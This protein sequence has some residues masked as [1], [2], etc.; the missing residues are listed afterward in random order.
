M[1]H[2]VWIIWKYPEQE[3]RFCISL[4]VQL[5]LD[6]PLM[7]LCCLQL[8]FHYE[9]IIIHSYSLFSLIS[10]WH[11]Q[12]VSALNNKDNRVDAIYTGGFIPQQH[13]C[14]TLSLYSWLGLVTVYFLWVLPS[15]SALC[16]YKASAGALISWENTGATSEQRGTW[17][18]KTLIWIWT[19]NL[20]PHLESFG[21]ISNMSLE[22]YQKAKL[23]LTQKRWYVV[24]TLSV[25]R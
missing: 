24:M 15:C 6:R 22:T 2:L 20:Q 25:A 11:L 1:L 13:A 19:A 23:M 17:M 8:P 10:W 16:S 5:A 9:T 14:M 4:N 18:A 12:G 21:L 3:G 7:Q